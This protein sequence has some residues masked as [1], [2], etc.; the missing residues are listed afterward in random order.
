MPLG[1]TPIIG[2]WLMFGV[3]NSNVTRTS[4][5]LATSRVIAFIEEYADGFMR[6]CPSRNRPVPRPNSHPRLGRRRRAIARRHDARH[7]PRKC[8]LAK[9]ADWQSASWPAVG[10]RW[11]SAEL[12]RG[13]TPEWHAGICVQ[14]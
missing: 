8:F 3:T 13:A 1:Q 6:T 7:R 5:L 12:A 14:A 9:R 2:V 11:V 4:L 10:A